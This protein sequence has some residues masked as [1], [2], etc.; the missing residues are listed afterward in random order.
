MT[1]LQSLEWIPTHWHTN[2]SHLPVAPTRCVLFSQIQS[3]REGMDLKCYI[4]T[5]HSSRITNAA[6]S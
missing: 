4:I 6:M 5:S 2:I 1:G 3:I